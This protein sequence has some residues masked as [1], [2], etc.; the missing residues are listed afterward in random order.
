L[1]PKIE[2]MLR[3]FE[4]NL[5]KYFMLD[6]I[7]LYG[8]YGSK[9]VPDCTVYGSHAFDACPVWLSTGVHFA[10]HDPCFRLLNDQSTMY[11]PQETA[12][13]W[14]WIEQLTE[15]TARF[16]H[17]LSMFTWYLLSGHPRRWLV[18]LGQLIAELMKGLCSVLSFV[19]ESPGSLCQVLVT[20]HF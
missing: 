9:I 5:S 7:E 2:E 13:T 15:H 19:R 18:D 17:V 11:L 6:W 3:T 1:K 12:A 20:Q 4:G 16:L 10:C 14:S 8:L